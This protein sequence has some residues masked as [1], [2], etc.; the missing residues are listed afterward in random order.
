MGFFVRLKE[1]IRLGARRRVGDLPLNSPAFL[2][3][4]LFRC[5][6]EWYYDH[7]PQKAAALTYR[8]IFSLIP[9]IVITLIVFR[10]F[11]GSG[12]VG[13][14]MLSQAYDYLGLSA[15]TFDPA[16]ARPSED[17]FDFDP[18]EHAASNAAEQR[19]AAID[20][21]M[22]TLA[23]KAS[24]VSFKGIAG[25]GII[26]FI[27]GAL[28]LVVTV[29]QTFNDIY[30][31]P[32]GRSWYWRITN[33]WAVL[34]LGPLLISIS[35]YLTGRITTAVE[36]N[37]GPIAPL[38]TISS[39]VS[40]LLASWLL[41]FLLYVLMPNTKVH[42]KPAAVGSFIAAVLWEIAKGGF[43]LYVTKAVPYANIYGVLGL[44][45]LFL[46]WVYVSWMIVLLGL[47]ITFMLQM[48][49]QGMFKHE[50]MFKDED[51]FHDARM[52]IPLMAAVA[53]GFMS[54]KAPTQGDLTRELGVPMPAVRMMA[55]HMQTAGLLHSVEVARGMDNGYTLAMPPDRIEI[56]RLLELASTLSVS[57]GER[58]SPKVKSVMSK[59][60]ESQRGAAAGLTLLDLIDTPGKPAAAS[61][62]TPLTQP[63]RTVATGR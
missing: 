41:L 4:F 19:T 42:R 56:S 1:H 8:S 52:L 32:I 16:A 45:P 3:N 31:T 21:I 63:G 9:V 58:S 46:L 61:D 5:G 28:G 10:A 26:M 59:L 57:T 7:A 11:P 24:N 18:Q 25:I 2:V 54:G 6:R 22:S 55:T 47:E 39:T 14:E 43:K 53:R 23:E 13:R 30:N 49:R 62:S 15:L 60:A 48:Y 35:L 36:G 37:L 51:L 38:L 40:A 29:E 27:W 33:Y 12:D 50:A 17:P 34:T 20:Q 44:V